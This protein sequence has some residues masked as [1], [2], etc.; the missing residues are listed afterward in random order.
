MRKIVLIT[1]YKNVKLLRLACNSVDNQTEKI[2][3]KY[4]LIDGGAENINHFEF[5]DWTILKSEQNIGQFGLFNRF[6]EKFRADRVFILD[7]DD[8]WAPNHVFEHSRVDADIVFSRNRLI[9]NN[10]KIGR[11]GGIMPVGK[12]SLKTLYYN[13]WIGPISQVSFSGKAFC[14]NLPIPKKLITNKDWYFYISI[15]SKEGIT[16]EFISKVTVFYRVWAGG[17]SS[18]FE[19]V[20]EGRKEF[21]RILPR[22][23]NNS[24]LNL[25]YY[26]FLISRN[27]IKNISFKEVVQNLEL[28]DLVLFIVMILYSKIFKL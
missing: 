6:K 10:N 19:K 16:V 23:L 15:L 18:N 17:V 13:N 4:I 5:S 14:D 9:N 3:E 11:K 7:S 24:K 28:T 20:Q 2:D 27:L 25:S 1:F 8:I 21:W 12:R 22:N 26:R